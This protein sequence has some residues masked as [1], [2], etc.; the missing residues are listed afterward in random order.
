MVMVAERL[1]PGQSTYATENGYSRGW[2][3]KLATGEAPMAGSENWRALNLAPGIRKSEPH[4]PS[5]LTGIRFV[6]YIVNGRATI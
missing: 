1:T 4:N 3:Q 2:N 6:G 5:G